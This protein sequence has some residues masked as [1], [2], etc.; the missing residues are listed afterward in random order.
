MKKACGRRISV[1]R[2]RLEPGS[3][4]VMVMSF[5]RRRMVAT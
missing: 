2:K 4:V 1:V 5:L 3:M